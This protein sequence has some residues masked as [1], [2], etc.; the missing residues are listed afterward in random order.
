VPASEEAQLANAMP[1]HDGD[2][3]AVDLVGQ[4]LPA[5]EPGSWPGGGAVGG[6]P[7]SEIRVFP[8]VRRRGGG[9]GGGAPALA[10]PVDLEP[11]NHERTGN[12][13]RAIFRLKMPPPGGA[14]RE[15]GDGGVGPDAGPFSAGAVL[16]AKLTGGPNSTRK[17]VRFQPS[18]CVSLRTTSTSRLISP[19]QKLKSEDRRSSAGGLAKR[20]GMTNASSSVRGSSFNQRRDAKASNALS[21]SLPGGLLASFASNS[22]SRGIHLPSRK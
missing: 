21:R 8:R 10:D 11:A 19:T 16:S 14:A 1:D 12:P 5:L 20:S 6:D 17:M 9:G 18:D 22:I 2:D 3:N 7:N 13:R 4:P 15:V